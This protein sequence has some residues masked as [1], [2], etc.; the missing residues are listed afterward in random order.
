MLKNAA[1]IADTNSSLPNKA[2]NLVHSEERTE[3]VFEPKLSG[4]K[5]L[6]F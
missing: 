4:Q 5:N 6:H 3:L 1:M 2:E